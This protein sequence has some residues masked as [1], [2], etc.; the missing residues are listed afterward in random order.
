M[1]VVCSSYERT[2]TGLDKIVL[3]PLVFT[4]G[5]HGPRIQHGIPKAWFCRYRVVQHADFQKRNGFPAFHL[6][7]STFLTHY[8][9]ELQVTITSD[10]QNLLARMLHFILLSCF[11]GRVLAATL[12][13][14]YYSQACSSRAHIFSAWIRNSPL[15]SALTASFTRSSWVKTMHYCLLRTD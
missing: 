6:N 8:I 12:E 14:V 1:A 15:T 5:P 10:S 4:S 9:L 13:S 3:C 11:L 7:P 2:A